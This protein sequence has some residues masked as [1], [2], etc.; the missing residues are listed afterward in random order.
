MLEEISRA[1]SVEDYRAY[2]DIIDEY[3]KWCKRRFD[4]DVWFINEVFGHQ[5]LDEEIADL[6]LKYGPPHGLTLIVR[7]DGE[8]AGA[9]AFRTMG[10]HVCE[11]KRVFVRDRFKGLGIGRRLC[12]ALMDT[13]HDEG[14]T[15]MRLDTAHRLTEAV[16]LYQSLGFKACTP[17]LSYPEKLMPYIL[18]MERPLV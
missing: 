16:G 4:D 6:P 5:S 18:F 2:A 9:G 7:R 10:T 11:M 12:R 1:S 14:Y 13:A 3:V 8:V 15:L 17:Y